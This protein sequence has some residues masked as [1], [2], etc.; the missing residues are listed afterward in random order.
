MPIHAVNQ[1]ARSRDHPG[2]MLQLPQTKGARPI[3]G[4]PSAT[5]PS[6]SRAAATATPDLCSC[7][8][9]TMR[10]LAM[11]LLLLSC[12]S[13]SSACTEIPKDE[14]CDLDGLTGPCI[15]LYESPQYTGLSRVFKDDVPDLSVEAFNNYT[16]SIKVRG[17]PWL[18]CDDKLCSGEERLEVFEEG[19][20]PHLQGFSNRISS[21]RAVKDSLR[22]PDILLCV[23]FELEGVRRN[24]S[25]EANLAQ[26]DVHDQISSHRVEDGVWLLSSDTKNQGR[27][28]VA[29]KGE[30]LDY[31]QYGLV[32]F[33]DVLSHVCPLTQG[34][35]VVLDIRPD[36]PQATITSTLEILNELIIE[37]KSPVQQ[38][39][40]VTHDLRNE[41]SVRETF[42]FGE[43]TVLRTGVSFYLGAGSFY[44]DFFVLV[45][46]ELR[47]ELEQGFWVVK[48]VTESRTRIVSRL[49]EFSVS[50]PANQTV[51]A[52]IRVEEK[53]YI[54][55]VVLVIREG[56]VIIEERANLTCTDRT[57]VTVLYEVV[58]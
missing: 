14:H 25:N 35:P 27:K 56:F 20:Y 43:Y 57:Y 32:S 54:I 6:Q 12:L 44:E 23:D 33:N 30:V 17:G 53:K 58:N 55:P 5:Q 47:L 48:D 11:W 9:S 36:C 22:D 29:R 15:V 10:C 38:V 26:S 1:D 8:D 39:L 19:C 46:V 28:R 42:T 31:T 37:N 7:D 41:L 24:F 49:L 16:Q 13:P 21:L 4:Q 52:I 45:G 40:T 2:S 50:V 51:K 18:A 3:K 34:K